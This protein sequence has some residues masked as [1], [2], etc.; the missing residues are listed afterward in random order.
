MGYVHYYLS[1][2]YE[3][4]YGA[5]KRDPAGTLPVESVIQQPQVRRAVMVVVVGE[6]I[7]EKNCCC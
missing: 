2:A 3:L 1:T 7:S 4:L 5:M 6:G